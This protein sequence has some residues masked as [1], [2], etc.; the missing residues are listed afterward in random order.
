MDHH[1]GKKMEKKTTHDFAERKKK[2]K[3]MAPRNWRR[4]C[5]KGI[6]WVEKKK[7]FL[8]LFFIFWENVRHT[9]ATIFCSLAN[10][11]S[12]S[13][14]GCYYVLISGEN[15]VAYFCDKLVIKILRQRW[16]DFFPEPNSRFPTPVSPPPGIHY[17]HGGGGSHI[18]QTSDDERRERRG[19]RKS[20][21]KKKIGDYLYLLFSQSFA[22]T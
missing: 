19:K 10:W 9:E 2:K 11:V 21:E 8:F 14:S 5:P 20:W 6:G 18:I 16:D 12:R 1:C 13:E 22:Y 7:S 4:R 3:S 15:R 17:L